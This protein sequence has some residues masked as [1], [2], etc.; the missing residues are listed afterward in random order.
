MRRAGFN[1][2]DR[3]VTNEVDPRTATDERQFPV[4]IATIAVAGTKCTNVL[5]LGENRASEVA[6]DE[7]CVNAIGV[8]SDER[9]AFLFGQIL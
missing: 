6:S 1:V 7:E 5:E 3:T 9:I 8:C 4:F 2:N